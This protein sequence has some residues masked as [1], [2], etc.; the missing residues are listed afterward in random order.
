VAADDGGVGADGDP[1]TN[2]GGPERDSNR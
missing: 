2:P 1:A